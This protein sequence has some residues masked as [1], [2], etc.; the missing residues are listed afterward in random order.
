MGAD[1][2][3]GRDGRRALGAWG[4]EMAARHLEASGW[5]VIERN[6]RVNEGEVDLIARREEE[7]YGE[8]VMCVIFVEVKTRQA[9]SRLPPE[10]SVTRVKRERLARLALRWQQRHARQGGVALRFDVIAVER[11][12]GSGEDQA[13]EVRHIEGAFDALGRL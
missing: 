1:E 5:E 13:S 7:R 6:W 12:R 11:A 4:E 2:A 9:G 8:P 3:A 10:R